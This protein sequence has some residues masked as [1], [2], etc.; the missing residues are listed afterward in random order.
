MFKFDQPLHRLPLLEVIIDEY[1]YRY[2]YSWVA[3]FCESGD[4]LP[5]GGEGLVDVCPFLLKTRCYFI[6]FSRETQNLMYVCIRTCIHL[7]LAAAVIQSFYPAK[8]I[9]YVGIVLYYINPCLSNF[10]VIFII[11]VII[12]VFGHLAVSK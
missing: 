12:A 3:Y 1:R 8:V 5:E 6:N 10:I 4:H 9:K 7:H 2:K 11:V